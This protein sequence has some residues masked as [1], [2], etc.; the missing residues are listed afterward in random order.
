MYIPL[1]QQK[2][3]TCGPLA[4]L[5][6]MRFYRPD[7][8]KKKWMKKIQWWCNCTA[9]MAVKGT[10]ACGMN[11]GLL[12]VKHIV[13]DYEKI[14]YPTRDQ[15]LFHLD[16]GRPVIMLYQCFPEE[17]DNYAGHFC[18]LFKMEEKIYGVGYAKYDRRTGE[19]T[20]PYK[21]GLKSMTLRD[22]DWLLYDTFDEFAEINYPTIWVPV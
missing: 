22:I 15:L 17:E 12:A 21:G 13:G 6:I 19:K 5:N 9:D 16:F 20:G 4:L 7:I 8:T 10:D 11:Y 14:N 1:I 2:S 18:V 3:Y